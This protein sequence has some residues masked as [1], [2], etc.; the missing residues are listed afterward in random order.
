MRNTDIG[1]VIAVKRLTAAKT[2]LAPEFSA[3]AREDVVLAM[4][5][6]TIT[7]ALAVP[8]VLSVLIV[9]P[10]EVAADAAKQLGAR[11]LLDPTPEGHRDP[12]NNALTAAEG[13]VRQE[14][15]NIVVLQGDL[16]ALKSRELDEA[17]VQ[18]RTHTRSFVADRHGTGTAALFSFDAALD[19]R[20][21]ADSAR[22]HLQSGAVELTGE[23]PGLRADIDTP[24][25]LAAAREL[26]LGPATAQAIA[27]AG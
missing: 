7:A 5:V 25:D 26:G 6:D 24:D 10:D 3:A 20:F 17:I 22:R 12:L 13:V 9:T 1:L 11:V 19:P 15:S 14:N 27:R 4:L 8:A 23:W 2:R 16:P 21:G 18:A